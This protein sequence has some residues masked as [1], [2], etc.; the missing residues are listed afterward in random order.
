ME[1]QARTYECGI[2][3]GGLAGLCLAIQ[4]ADQGI[5][6]VLFEKNQYPFHKVCGEYI[7]FESFKFLQ[8]LGL[9]LPEW[10]LPTIKRLQVSDVKGRSYNF[11]LDLGGFGISRYKIDD[12]LYQLAIKKKSTGLHQYKSK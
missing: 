9:P 12:A 6:V 1:T 7:S 4:L 10:N 8:S 5:S 2:I 11:D 3:G